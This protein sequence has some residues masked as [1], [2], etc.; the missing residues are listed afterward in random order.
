MGSLTPAHLALIDFLAEVAV[1]EYLTAEAAKQQDS[2][3]DCS[4]R[5]PLPALDEAA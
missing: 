2:D 5:V 4:E 1:R 3:P